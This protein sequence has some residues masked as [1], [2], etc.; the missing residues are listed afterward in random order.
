MNM[1]EKISIR[2]SECRHGRVREFV[3]QMQ[4]EMYQHGAKQNPQA[5]GERCED[6]N[7]GK[8]RDARN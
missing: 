6:E 1:C 4:D 3:Y 7:H 2:S 5:R 8:I